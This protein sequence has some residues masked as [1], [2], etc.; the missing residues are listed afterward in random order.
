[1]LR[2]TFCAYDKPDSVGGPFSWLQRLLPALRAHGIEARCLVLLH[3]GDTG[4]TLESLRAQGIACESTLCHE[5]TEDRIRWI[6]ERLRE[7]PPDVFVPNLPVAAYFA[8]AWLRSA[9]IP[10]LGILHSDDSFYRGLQDEF[11]IGPKRF[12]LSGLVCVSRELEQQI[13]ARR[14][15]ST[16]VWR[17]PYGVPVP[18]QPVRREPGVLR[19]AYVGRLAEEQKRITEVTRGLCRVISEVPATTAVIFGDGPD[20]LAVETILANEGNELPIRLGGLVPSGRIQEELLNCDVTVLLSD[21]EGLPIALMEAMACGCV[22][23]CLQMRSG[24]PE[25]IK[26]GENGL[27]VDD[28]G[29]GLVAAIRRLRDEAGLWER[30]SH[31]ARARIEEEFSDTLCNGQWAAMLHELADRA[32]RRQTIPVPRR[33]RISARNPA[34]EIPGNRLRSAP[35]SIRLWHCSRILAGRIKR[36]LLVQPIP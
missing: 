3:C 14:P 32:T 28:R 21:Y 30:L 17:I 10:T 1:M 9:G 15:Q 34:L 18:D 31:A 36:R 16:R 7:H 12:R 2:V 13:L 4:P 11:V 26:D 27:L 8:A 6:L 35:L 29:D 19:L 22:P 24:I 25:L 5:R 33:L 23:V 20:K